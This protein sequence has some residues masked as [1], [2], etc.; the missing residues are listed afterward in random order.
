M[1]IREYIIGIGILAILLT[2]AGTGSAKPNYGCTPSNCHGFDGNFYY[3]THKFDGISS[4]TVDTSCAKCHVNPTGDMS[5]TSSGSVYSETHRYNDTTLASE[6]LIPPACGNCHV[7]VINNDFT[8]LSGNATYLTSKTCENCHK[9]KY[10]NWTNT[11]HRVMLTPKTTAQAMGLPEPEVG[12]ANISYVIITKSVIEYINTTGWF[13]SNNSAW[14]TQEEKWGEGHSGEAY[15]NCAR[16]HA[17]GYNATNGNQSGM[18]GIYGSWEEPGIGCE[19][20]H[21]PA[22]NGHQVDVNYSPSLCQECHGKGMG[23][24]GTRWELGAHAP[25]AQENGSCMYC[26]SPIDQ[27]K[28]PNVTADNAGNVVCAV[29]HNVH[30]LSDDQYGPLFSPNG[31]NKTIMADEKAAKLSFFNATASTAA[32]ADIYDILVSPAEYYPGTG[33]GITTGDARKD[34]SYGAAPISVTG[35]ISNALCSK[36]HFRHGLGHIAAVNLSHGTFHSG[37]KNTVAACIDC[38]ME[39][40]GSN[41]RTVMRRHSLDPLGENSCGGTTRCHTTSDQNLSASSNSVIPVINEWNASAHNDKEVGVGGDDYNHFYWNNTAGVPNS[42]EI[43]C[44]KCHSPMDWNPVRDSDTTKV[45]LTDDFKGITCAVC[46]NL[47]DT[48]DWLARTQAMF[49]EAKGYAWY[50]KDAIVAATNA[51]TGLPSRY[52]A[53]YTMIGST[54]ELCGNCHSNIRIG[55]TGPGYG[56]PSTRNPTGIISPHGFPAK[57]IFVGSWKQTNNFECID[58]HMATKITDPTNLTETVLPDSQKVKGHSFKVNVPLLENGTCLDCHE[59]GN[60]SNRIEV[61]KVDTQTK[62]NATNITVMTALETINAFTGPKNLSRDL[63][64]QA[65]WNMRFVSSDESWGVHNPVGVNMLLD[66]ATALANEALTNLG[67][68]QKTITVS[69]A[70]TTLIIGETQ[71]FTAT[72]LDQNSTPLTGVNINWLSNNTTVGNVSP[73]TAT[74]DVS[75]AVTTTFTAGAA[76]I[77]MITANNGTVT[78]SANVIVTVSTGPPELT[79]IAVSPPMITLIIGG[80]QTITATAK[81]QNGNPVQGTNIT[82]TNSNTAVGSVAPINVIT[83]VNG[84]AV[85]TF[86]AITK[87]TSIIDATNGTVSGSANVNVTA[88]TPPTNVTV[89]IRTIEKESL[90]MGESANITVDISSDISQ[91]LS[92]REIIPTGWNLTRITDDA[93]AFKSSTN[94]WILFNVTPGI[95]ITVVYRLTALNF[96]TIGTYHINGTISNSSGVIAVVQGDNTITLDINAFYR[97]LGSDSNK[98]ETTDVLKAGDDWRN[99]IAPPGF[100]RAITRMELLALIEEWL[101]S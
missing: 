88:E 40:A 82:W 61:I 51:T 28:N 95:H 99:N 97:R 80:T 70:T 1:K 63:I 34:P 21:K 92:L 42:R 71:V 46:H 77:A 53:N 41:E 64:A 9:A 33:D 6:R 20:C 83:D 65:Y 86:T 35:A 25:P 15:K 91:A 85:T 23:S 39:K 14:E 45:P 87:G 100:D 94:E 36:C 68:G 52:K 17:T 4:P 66:N 50:N 24:H 84:N 98:V 74:T 26:H 89:A 72:F 31:F 5:L 29:C 32:G 56:T 44:N 54:T 30:D 55:N 13:P 38:H 48:G 27:Y 43:S 49:G 59:L 3:N 62:W 57:D 10:D 73:L 7:D 76:G 81:D 19:R 22:G 58:C 37:D 8:R 2:L 16:C 75:G 60:I 78:G 69:P 93:D 101:V 67:E 12:W 47:H 79:T 96:A 90:R 11:L 18:L